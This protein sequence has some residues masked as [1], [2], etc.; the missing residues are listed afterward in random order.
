MSDEA[1]RPANRFTEKLSHLPLA[2]S[3][4][5]PSAALVCKSCWQLH[6]TENHRPIASPALQ[7][8]DCGFDLSLCPA[9]IIV[10]FISTLP[11]LDHSLRTYKLNPNCPFLLFMKLS[12]EV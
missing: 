8:P 5:H 3:G 11:G 6:A 7:P 1:R 9:V 4:L 10:P 12:S 2:S